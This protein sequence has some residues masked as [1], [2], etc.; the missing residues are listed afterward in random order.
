MEKELRPIN[1]YKMI[2]K[3]YGLQFM[4]ETVREIKTYEM[5]SK[6]GGLKL[7]LNS[8]NSRIGQ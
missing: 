3:F 5:L 1:I 4:E 6:F 7:S 2:S 8:H